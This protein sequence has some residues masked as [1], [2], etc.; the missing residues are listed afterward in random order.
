MQPTDPY[1]L[2]TLII[3]SMAVVTYWAMPARR[4]FVVERPAAIGALVAVTLSGF[5][6]CYA[7]ISSERT[8]YTYDRQQN[9]FAIAIAFDLSPSM[10][11]IPHPSFQE[12]VEPRYMR[13]K[14][15]VR[16]FLHRLEDNGEVA[17]VSIIG[18]TRQADILMGWDNNPAQ[19]RDIIEYAVAPDLLG[20]SG[21]SFEAA[22]RSLDDVFRLLPGDLQANGRKLLIIVS[23]GEDTMRSSSFAYAEE[24]LALTNTDTIAVQT[25]LLDHNEG[26]PIYGEYGDFAEFRTIR[27][28]TYTV[29]NVAAMTSIANVSPGRGIYVRAESPDAVQSMLN[30][31]IESRAQQ[32]GADAALLSTFGMFTVLASLCAAIIR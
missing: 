27:G 18:F 26:I 23:D 4:K 7:S 25:G 10:L 2:A 14:T 22:A 20:S 8:A 31:A 28:T 21:T 19:V 9:P 32:R 3:L 6:F 1:F 30:F 11:A 24:T 12:G 5:V 17:F 16:D 15:V 29:P 13:G